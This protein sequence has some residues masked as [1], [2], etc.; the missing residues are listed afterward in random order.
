MKSSANFKFNS[1]PYAFL[2]L[3]LISI[4]IFILWPATKAVIQSFFSSNAFGIH[5]YFIWFDNF[6]RIFSDHT[7]LNSIWI[8][9]VFSISITV[10]VIATGLFMAVLANRTRII[11]S[12]YNTLFIWPYAV[13][14]VIS[15][16]LWSFLF[17]PAVG[18]VE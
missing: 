7:Y 8:T 5:N 2:A 11:K 3:Q 1:W 6:K 14:P 13:A 17:N 10:L 12:F 9:L 18:V 16:V 4:A 15:G